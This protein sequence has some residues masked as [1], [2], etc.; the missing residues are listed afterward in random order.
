MSDKKGWDLVW[1]GNEDKVAT[2]ITQWENERKNK[3]FTAEQQ[4]IRRHQIVLREEQDTVLK[5]TDE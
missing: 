3:Q 1:R 4:R 5:L 2:W